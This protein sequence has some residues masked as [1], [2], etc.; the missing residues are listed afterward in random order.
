MPL[1]EN[2]P[3][4]ALRIFDKTLIENTILQ[5]KGLVEEVV[6]VIGY[7]GEI[8]KEIV[9][10]NYEGIPIRYVEQEKQLGTGDAALKAL[11][12]LGEEFIIF[13]G[14]DIYCREDIKEMLK[15][16]P[17]ILLKEV[18]DPSGCGQ[19]VVEKEKVK[20]IV[21]KPPSLVSNLVNVGCYH[22]T[23]SF[24]E[25]NINIS[26]RG[27]YEIV[28]YVNNFSEEMSFKRTS[29]WYAV[30]YPW[31]LLD[32]MDCVS[33]GEKV[34]G[35]VEEGAH[36]KGRL[37]LGKGSIIKGGSRIEG[38]VYVGENTVIGPNAYLRDCAVH[39]NC[40]IGN[41]VEVKKSLILSGSSVAHLSY[42]GDSV[43]GENC[44]VG[45]GTIT[46]NMRFDGGLV[47]NTARKKMGV[48]MGDNVKVGIN[49][50]IMPGEIIENNTIINPHTY[51][52]T[53]N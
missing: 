35:E 51:V 8:I 39:D 30:S 28:D 15:K 49:C 18:D 26:S 19:A 17:C 50:S 29:E 27:E 34:E 38:S 32:A 44:L 33:M 25:K 10:D 41:G 11:P 42:I 48:I 52:R 46:A 2:R 20:K 14:D 22:L 21:E 7:K 31:N 3:K 1:T 23:K 5:L 47:K 36:I 24:F 53:G 9:G 6:V 16:A 45:A 37:F 12:F 43:I 13:N 40:R 4:P